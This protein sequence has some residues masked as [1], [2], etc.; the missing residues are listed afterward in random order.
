MDK[1]SKSLTDLDKRI[2]IFTVGEVRRIQHSLETTLRKTL[3]VVKKKDQR[4]QGK[5]LPVGSYYSDLK[6][7][8]PDEFDYL[9]ELESIQEKLNFE[10]Q[11]SGF[12]GSKNLWR[13]PKGDPGKKK[14]LLK[15]PETY[16]CT[17]DSDDSVKWLHCI[18]GKRR[19]DI[20]NEYVLDP[21]GVKNTSLCSLGGHK[22]YGSITT[23]KILVYRQNTR[24]HLLVWSGCDTIL[25]MEWEILQELKNHSRFDCLYKN[26]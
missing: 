20:G 10:V 4:L 17:Q 26:S 15:T 8:F 22:R 16:K 23:S 1:L 25:H 24:S 14:I 2:Q 3:D 12:S 5:L 9:Y 21:V 13:T 11:P 7:G 18:S 19:K 6:I